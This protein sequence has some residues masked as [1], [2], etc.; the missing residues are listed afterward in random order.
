MGRSVSGLYSLS[1]FDRQK[2]KT[3]IQT[4][5]LYPT[6]SR[7]EI[8]PAYKTIVVMVLGNK[9]CGENTPLN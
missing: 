8:S 5:K 2:Q 1:Q 9:L 4:Q 6:D 7:L 3:Q